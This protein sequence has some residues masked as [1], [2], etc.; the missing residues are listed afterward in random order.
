MKR[1]SCNQKEVRTCV[2][3]RPEESLSDPQEKAKW[4]YQRGALSF[5][6]GLFE[7]LVKARNRST[8]TNFWVWTPAGVVGVLLSREDIRS[9]LRHRG[10]L[11]QK[12]WPVSTTE[13]SDFA[14]CEFSGELGWNCGRAKGSGNL[15]WPPTIATCNML[16]CC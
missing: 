5:Q 12:S 14:I 9:L 16:S 1:A 6:E 4:W 13:S 15:Q 2:L 10:P 7:A 8:K 3:A 11:A